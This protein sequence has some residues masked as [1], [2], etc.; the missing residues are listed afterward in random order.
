ML[1]LGK[2]GQMDIRGIIK[3]MDIEMV[4][5]GCTVAD[6][7]AKM[8]DRNVGSVIVKRGNRSEA[9]GIVTRQDVLF[10]VI[11]EGRDL[12]EVKVNEI[13]SFPVSILNNVDLDIRYAAR[14]MA[15]AGVTNLAIFDGGD[16]YGFLSSTDIIEAI[17]RELTVKS[18]QKKTE[19]IS[20]GC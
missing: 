10:K 19:D 3:R 6:A 11:A 4:D 1:W 8:V 20:G 18:L 9:Y 2:G 7:V 17:R 13:M 5:Q 12:N 16:F 14:A 15:N